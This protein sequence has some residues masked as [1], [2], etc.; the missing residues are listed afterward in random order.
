MRKSVYQL[1]ADVSQAELFRDC[2]IEQVFDDF[3]AIFNR[4]AVS[5]KLGSMNDFELN[6][7]FRKIEES[8]SKKID[9]KKLIQP[10]VIEIESEFNREEEAASDKLITMQE[11]SRLATSFVNEF[12]TNDD[13]NCLDGC[14][15]FENSGIFGVSGGL[16]RKRRRNGFV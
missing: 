11:T 6:R 15:L 3:V 5:N 16:I 14:D 12:Q 4:W 7:H 13:K 9:L 10:P 8:R 2:L 1:L